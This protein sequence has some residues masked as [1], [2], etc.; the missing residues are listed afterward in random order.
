MPERYVYWGNCS[1]L[2]C[3]ALVFVAPHPESPD[4][5]VEAIADGPSAWEGMGMDCPVCDEGEI[6]WGGSDPLPFVIRGD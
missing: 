5:T 1:N 6:E 3:S 4:A 2:E